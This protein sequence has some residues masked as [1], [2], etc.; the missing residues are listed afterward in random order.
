MKKV[1]IPMVAVLTLLFL[2]SFMMPDIP[3]EE[4][5]KLDAFSGIGISISAEWWYGL[6]ID[7]LQHLVISRWRH[8]DLV[9][10]HRVVTLTLSPVS[11]VH[12]LGVNVDQG[13]AAHRGQAGSLID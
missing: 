8:L 9:S 10:D 13:H 5:R 12:L 11:T 7:H 3:K 4:V 2:N 1:M 6:V